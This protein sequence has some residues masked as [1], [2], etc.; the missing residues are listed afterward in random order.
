MI[1]LSEEIGAVKYLVKYPCKQTIFDRCWI[2]QH[3]FP[4]V[5]I[6]YSSKELFYRYIS[7]LV[8][9][10]RHRGKKLP[11][12]EY[13]LWRVSK[14]CKRYRIACVSVIVKS[15][16]LSEFQNYLVSD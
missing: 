5:N 8:T 16:T 9:V 4:L 10:F 15:T 12:M 11:S 7:T 2:A 14:D 1:L 3:L 13:V 6:I